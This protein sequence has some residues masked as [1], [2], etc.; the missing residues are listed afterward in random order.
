LTNND[1]N[2]N[3][4]TG[5]E[6]SIFPEPATMNTATI[7]K[8]D[9]GDA[10]Y[11]MDNKQE[12]EMLESEKPSVHYVEHASAE[13]EQDM[14]GQELTG[15]EDL[16]LFQTLKTFKKTSLLCLAVTFTACA[17]GYEVNHCA[18]S[19]IG[20]IR[21]IRLVSTDRD[22]QQYQCQRGIQPRGWRETGR[23]REKHF[24]GPVRQMVA[25]LD[26]WAGFGSSR[27]PLVG[28]E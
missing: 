19:H 10:S 22:D 13:A 2:S 4:L 11:N 27:V 12:V 8:V 18:T 3:I 23:W 15:Y 24:C 6:S 21:L 28:D 17:E 26:Y 16:T 7:N 25:A 1:S 9:T 20:R 14:R 5:Q